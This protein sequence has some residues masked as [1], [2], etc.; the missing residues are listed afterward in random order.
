ML[1]KK[2]KEEEKLSM[3]GEERRQKL[4]DLLESSDQPLSGTFLAKELSVS[5]QVIVQDIAILRANGYS[6]ISTNKGYIIGVDNNFAKVN[7]VCF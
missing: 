2:N 4:I 5:R 1:V 7:R 6:I 3:K